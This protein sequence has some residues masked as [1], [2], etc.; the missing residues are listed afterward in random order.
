[1]R[2]QMYDW[3]MM[4]LIVNLEL[5]NRIRVEGGFALLQFSGVS[6]DTRLGKDDSKRFLDYIEKK[7]SDK[8]V[9]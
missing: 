1:M 4:F 3:L 5:L 7:L 9:E 6:A 2:I 8:L